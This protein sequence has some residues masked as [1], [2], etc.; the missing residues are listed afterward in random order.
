MKTIIDDSG[1]LYLWEKGDLHISKGVVKEKEI[2]N[3]VIKTNKKKKKRTC[4]FN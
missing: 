2:K 4:Y 1:N 3:G